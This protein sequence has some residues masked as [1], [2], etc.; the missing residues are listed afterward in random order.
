MLPPGSDAKA[1]VNTSLDLR[2]CVFGC[3]FRS[4]MKR[5]LNYF[6][7]TEWALLLSSMALIIAVFIF[8]KEK[9]YLSFVSSLIGVSAL[10]LSAKGNPIGQALMIVFC[11]LYGIISFLFA[12][13]GEVL[14]YVFMTG[15]MAVY[16]LISWL[17]N[18]Y[19]SNKAEVK[20]NRISKKDVGIML[21]LALIVTL[22]FY[23]ILK[24]FGTAHLLISTFS[25]T[26]SFM[27]VF[28]TA[29]RSPFYAI[30]YAAN[31]VVLVV[32]WTIASILRPEYISTV[33]CFAV[34]LVND[35][36]GFINWRRMEKR[37]QIK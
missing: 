6:T 21:F 22:I 11:I 19:E 26:T 31:D 7:K 23:Y 36:Y 37:Q 24:W 5:I 32:L 9:D 25:V 2:R 35:I 18:P 8:S 17:K 30:A 12:Y 10:I 33:I 27:A 14:T 29:K 1:S 3:F 13:Y 4:N 28:L 16:A 15:P 20:V 34:F